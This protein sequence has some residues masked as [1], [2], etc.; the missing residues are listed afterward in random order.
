[1]RFRLRPACAFWITM[2]LPLGWTRWYGDRC[3]RAELRS[4]RRYAALYLLRAARRRKA[5]GR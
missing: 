1:M 4:M 5:L 2:T 3:S